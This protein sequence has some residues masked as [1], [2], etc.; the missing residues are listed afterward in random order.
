MEQNIYTYKIGEHRHPQFVQ[1][2]ADEYSTTNISL[3][4]LSKKYHTDASYQFKINGIPKRKGSIQKMLSRTGCITLNWKGEN[5]ETEKQAYI[6]GMLFSDGY[7]GKHQLGL[8]L[9]KSDKELLEQIKNYFS[10]DIKLQEEKNDFSFVVSSTAVCANFV[11]LGLL[12]NKTKIGINVPQ[13]DKSLYRHFIR[14]YFDG[15]GTVYVCNTKPKHSYLKAYI[16]SATVSILNDIQNILSVHNIESTINKEDRKGK[17]M[18][19]PQGKTFCSMDMFR[20]FIRK[21]A[22]LEKFYHFLYDDCTICLERKRR[23]FED[24]FNLLKYQKYM[25][26]PS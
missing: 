20:L 4:D 19:V 12:K 5:I 6:T 22:E 11:K 21:K 9:K 15:D 2:L 10:K 24:N 25:P 1:M 7:V 14:G 17:V 18:K 3:K 13:M 26:I 16:C 23:K 8:R